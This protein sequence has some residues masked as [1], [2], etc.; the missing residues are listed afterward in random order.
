M[1]RL[2]KFVDSVTPMVKHALEEYSDPTTPKYIR[3]A[4]KYRFKHGFYYQLI[5]Y[6]PQYHLVS[7]SALSLS[8]E[9]GFEDLCWNIQWDDQPKYDPS[10]KRNT[11]HIEHVFTGEMFFHALKNM[12][13]SG[14]LSRETLSQFI[15]D[16]YRT[17]WILKEED[18]LLAKSKRG[19][20]LDDA[21]NHYKEVGI[22]LLQREWDLPEF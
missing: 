12:N 11:F 8:R 1:S 4:T 5:Q 22:E 20:T 17:A 15:R 21:L 6:L 14:G 7:R 13:E 10:G 3:R 19:V 9:L 18:R 2:D 16:N